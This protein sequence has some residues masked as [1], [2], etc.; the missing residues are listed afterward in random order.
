MF[1]SRPSLQRLLIGAT[2]TAALALPSIVL[3]SPASAAALSDTVAC[4]G[5]TMR[6]PTSTPL[7]AGDTYTINFTGCQEIDVVSPSLTPTSGA[8]RVG[9]TTRWTLTGSSVVFSVD[10]TPN[11]G[12]LVI[13]YK[14]ADGGNII[15]IDQ[16]ASASPQAET[17][18]TGPADVIQQTGVPASG[19]CTNVVDAEFAYGT[20]VSGGWGKSW[21]RWINAGAGGAVC[22][23]TL[24][25]NSSLAAWVIAS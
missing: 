25:Y 24:T 2:A 12:L 21:A 19:N 5:T 15:M 17:A 6:V 16:P 22:T 18:Q 11:P 10:S 3:A 13:I 1:S 8:T 20:K 14:L 23:R 4:G 9:V 7:A